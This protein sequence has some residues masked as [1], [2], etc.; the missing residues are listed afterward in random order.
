MDKATILLI[1]D[2]PDDVELTLHSFQKNH[3]PNDS[4]VAT[5]GA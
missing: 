1:E 3:M 5:D 2:N 4:V